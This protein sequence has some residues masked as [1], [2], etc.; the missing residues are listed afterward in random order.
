MYRVF[1]KPVCPFCLKAKK[2][3]ERKGC[4][5]EYIDITQDELA[6]E[7]IEESGY[8]TVPVVYHEGV[9]IGGHEELK[10]KLNSQT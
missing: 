10:N 8:P 5:F 7:F 1:G 4:D 9:L 3:L 6:R 2:L